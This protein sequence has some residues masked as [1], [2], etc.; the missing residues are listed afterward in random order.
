MNIRPT[1]H[2]RTFLSLCA[3]ILAGATTLFMFTPDNE[4][5][6]RFIVAGHT[7]G[8]PGSDA[9]GLHP[10]FRENFDYIKRSKNM[11]FAVF[12]GD[13]VRKSNP[14]AWDRVDDDNRSLGL[15]I[16]FS[17]G[18]HDHANRQLYLERYGV[19]GKTYYSFSHDKDLFIIL[20]GNKAGWSIT[21]EQLS[22]LTE[23]LKNA[24]RYDNVF[25]FVHQLI[26]WDK[27]EDFSKLHPNS[28]IGRKEPVNFWPELMP[29]FEQLSNAVYIFAGDT[30]AFPGSSPSY[31][32]YKNV[33]LIASGMGGGD[34]DNFLI[35]DRSAGAE[36]GIKIW[37]KWL[38]KDTPELLDAVLLSRQKPG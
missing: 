32:Q 3:V 22:F 21:G 23:T 8:K 35:V 5:G 7:Y 18:N 15:P 20:D 24:Q 36:A 27:R 2:N 26:W 14:A 16:H 4:P 19:E 28:M 11:A 6:Y 9:L 17:P 38:S 25:V 31:F 1:R 33:S 13:I 37:V 10:P 12:T 30:G 29:M 34:V